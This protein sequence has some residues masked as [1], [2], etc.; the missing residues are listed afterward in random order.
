[1]TAVDDVRRRFPTSRDLDGS[2]ALNPDPDYSAAYLV[3]STDD[4]P[5]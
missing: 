1:M 2:D 4:G 5:D 3:L